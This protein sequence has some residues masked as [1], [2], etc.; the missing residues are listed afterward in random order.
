MILIDDDG[1]Q[2]VHGLVDEA[3]QDELQ[4]RDHERQPKR[5]GV[6]KDVQELLPEDREER[7]PH[8]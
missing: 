5:A 4:D 8:G 6:A 3:E 7:A 1:R 2:I